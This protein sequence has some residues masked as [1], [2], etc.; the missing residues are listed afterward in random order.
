M[1]GALRK[2]WLDDWRRPAKPEPK[3]KAAK[4]LLDQRAGSMVRE[5]TMR[6]PEDLH[7]SFAGHEV[8]TLLM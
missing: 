2:R 8:W 5:I 6:P 4:Q 7:D 1:G 3:P